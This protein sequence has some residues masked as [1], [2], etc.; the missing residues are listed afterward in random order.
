MTVTR[1]WLIQPLKPLLVGL[2][3]KEPL[4]CTS[5]PKYASVLR[6]EKSHW[7]FPLSAQYGAKPKTS[8]ANLGLL[9]SRAGLAP[10]ADIAGGPLRVIGRSNGCGLAVAGASVSGWSAWRASSLMC[11]P[12]CGSFH[13]WAADA[14]AAC[15]CAGAGSAQTRIAASA[16]PAPAIAD[17]FLARDINGPTPCAG[18][19]RET[20]NPG[21]T[22]SIGA[23]RRAWV[24]GMPG[25]PPT[26]SRA[27][28]R[29]RNSGRS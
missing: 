2:V 12:A 13:G 24:P 8:R 21:T 25:C 27:V 18:R 19:Q 7:P 22:I 20:S 14:D 17:R 4:L 28:P 11:G 16:T 15:A 5:S 6:R 9:G 3:L 29:T 1:S 10:A 26:R 23:M